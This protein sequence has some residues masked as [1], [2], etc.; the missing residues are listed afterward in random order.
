[1]K[2]LSQLGILATIALATLLTGCTAAPT[3]QAT[4]PAPEPVAA[5]V[6]YGQQEAFANKLRAFFMD[7]LA[8]QLKVEINDDAVPENKDAKTASTLLISQEYMSETLARQIMHNGLLKAATKMGFSVVRF[9][10][11]RSSREQARIWD[12][13]M[14]GT[15]KWGFRHCTTD[16]KQVEKNVHMTPAQLATAPASTTC[17]D[18]LQDGLSL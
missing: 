16:W 12:Y 6:T 14:D 2:T 5:P 9:A 1:M 18:E 15:A 3:T 10:N 13:R 4:T 11:K 7:E 17:E 8:L